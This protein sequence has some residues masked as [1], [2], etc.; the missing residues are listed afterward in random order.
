[1]NKS[2]SPRSDQFEE[3]LER[4]G[5][6]GIITAVSAAV[7]RRYCQLARM[8]G[9]TPVTMSRWVNNKA[10]PRPQHREKLELLYRKFVNVAK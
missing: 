3:I 4:V 6:G 5:W 8:F 9:V 1:M 2:E 10:A 7:D